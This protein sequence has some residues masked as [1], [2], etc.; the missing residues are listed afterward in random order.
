MKLLPSHEPWLITLDGYSQLAERINAVATLPQ[1]EWPSSPDSTQP[2]AES[3][4]PIAIVRMHGT[5]LLGLS[6][7]LRAL[8]DYFEI[9]VTDT[10]DIGRTLRA[11][12][13]DEHVKVVVLDINSPGG[14]VTGTPELAAAVK[15]L[16]SKKYV[17]AYTSDM[18]CSAA[19]WIASQCDAVYAAPS[20]HLGSIGVLLP[21]ID[22]RVKLEKA[23]L[24]VDALTAGKYKGAGLAGTSL[25]D[26]QRE[27]LQARVNEDWERFKQAVN[28]RR[29]I[30]SEHME[31][32]SF[33]GVKAVELGLADA[34]INSLE[35]LITKLTARHRL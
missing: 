20:A 23:G 1:A 19:Y 26:E 18:A 33:T 24:T 6:P 16:S 15:E 8:L 17:Y 9:A 31:G 13:Q 3:P 7:R 35:E 5:M 30:A 25:T 28:T 34:N 11:L 21:L 27:L 14:R 10:A 29:S 32:Q 12:K 2:R 22:S 4:S